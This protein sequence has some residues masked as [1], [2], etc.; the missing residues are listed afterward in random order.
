MKNKKKDQKRESRGVE[1]LDREMHEDLISMMHFGESEEVSCKLCTDYHKKVCTGWDLSG[2]LNVT[3]CM[4]LLIEVDKAEMKQ[5]RYDDGQYV[6]LAHF[7][8]DGIAHVHF[9]A[10]GEK[11][12]QGA[13][14]AEEYFNKAI[15][16][17]ACQ[18]EHN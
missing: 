18:K 6:V 16:R 4:N 1:K 15:A 7:S 5:V 14:K 3:I 13:I 17:S 2:E 10:W 11:A 12:V 9:A 8:L